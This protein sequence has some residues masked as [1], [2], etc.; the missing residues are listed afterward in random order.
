MVDPRW[1]AET[2][3]PMVEAILRAFGPERTM[4]GSNVPVESLARPL[5]HVVRDTRAAR[6]LAG[7]DDAAGRA[8]MADAARRFYRLAA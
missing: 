3:A 6:R 5:A 4:W 7:C 8:V 1:T 2:V